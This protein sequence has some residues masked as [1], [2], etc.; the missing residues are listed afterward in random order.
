[1][2]R[3]QITRLS[4]LVLLALGPAWGSPVTGRCVDQT[5]CLAFLKDYH[6]HLI[7]VPSRINERSV[8]AWR[9]VE[10]IDLD[11]VP[12]VIY[13]ANCLTSHS[14]R[15]VDSAFSLESIPISIN[16]PVLRK[17]RRCSSYALEFETV[18]IACICATTRQPNESS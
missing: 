11:R 5:F 6:S 15:D 13:E 12:Q 7:D 14:C 17:S 18:T 4:C 9:Y 8:A 1:M 10:K 3:F 2:L 16:M